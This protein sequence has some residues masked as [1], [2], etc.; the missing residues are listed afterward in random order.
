MGAP[1]NPL[2][3]TE[4]GQRSRLWTALEGALRQFALRF[5]HALPASVL[6]FD[7][8]KNVAEVQPLIQ[9]VRVDQTTMSRHPLANVPVLSLGGGGFHC[10]F[11]LKQGDLG[12]IFATDRDYSNFLASLKESAPN[13]AR[14]HKFEDSIFVPDVFRQYTINAADATAMVIQSTDGG[15]RIA[16]DINGHV[17]ITAPTDLI[18]T[19][20]KTT[21]TG[22]VEIQGNAT[23]DQTLTVDGAADIKGTLTNNGIDVTTHGH[24]SNGAGVR[25]QNMEN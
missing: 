17:R 1:L 5:D 15:T 9:V 18:I 19:T 2:I 11:P 3:N 21:F 12:W 25:T 10:S 4:A 16:I 22:D 6:S 20:P 14:A 13:S 7:R 8:T 23:L 24:I